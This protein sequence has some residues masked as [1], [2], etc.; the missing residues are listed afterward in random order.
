M[1]HFCRLEKKTFAHTC[2]SSRR[3]KKVKNATKH[4]GQ[5]SSASVVDGHNWLYPIC[6]GVFDSETNENW[7]WFMSQLREAIGSPTGL[8][9]STNAG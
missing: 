3:N 5:L 9:I 4:K 2:S 8:A 7:I 1:F 6:R